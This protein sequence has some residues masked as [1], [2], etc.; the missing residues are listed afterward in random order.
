MD[1]NIKIYHNPRCSK[2][3]QALH[4]LEESSADFEVVEYLKDTPTVEELTD[5]IKKLGINPIALVRKGEEVFKTNFKDKVLSDAEWIEAMVAFPKLI[6]RPIVVKGD[7]AV[8]GRPID[9]VKK[10]L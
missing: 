2:S 3:R 5:I 1:Q 7:K 9:A 4:L 6:E 8:I 10:L